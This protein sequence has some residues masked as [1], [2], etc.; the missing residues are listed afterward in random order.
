MK[1]ASF[2]RLLLDNQRAALVLLDESL[3]ISYLNATAEALLYTS[4]RKLASTPLSRFFSDTDT[5]HDVFSNCLAQGHPITCHE[6][7]VHSP[8]TE[9]QVNLTVSRLLPDR[10][11]PALLVEIQ[12]LDR[13]LRHSQEEQQQQ[14]HKAARHMVR[15]IA[16]EVKNPL[17][18]I[19]GA[20]QLLNG[21]HPDS[22]WQKCIDIIIDESDRL[23]DLT[24][25]LLGSKDR[26]NMH[27]INIHECLERARLLVEQE[28]PAVTIQRDYDPSL[29]NIRA[30]K[31]LLIQALLN[32]VRNAMQTLMENRIEN[33]FIT[34]R[35]RAQ[36]Q[37][38]IHNNHHRLALRIDIEDNGPGV[39]D[40][41]QNALF[42][43][44]VTGR[45]QGAGLGLSITQDIINHHQGM[46]ECESKPG[47]T[48]FRLLLPMNTQRSQRHA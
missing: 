21:Y 31:N 40:S 3:C 26:P 28:Q 33:G 9:T 4:W 29:P 42:F 22:Q 17:G 16:H 20:A 11:R 43:P 25:R 41:L 47:H 1:D 14:V 38:T 37:V 45:A 27:D 44:L 13:H 34:L 8:Y 23:S 7:E 18:G 10:S 48:C 32:L 5:I 24:N 2:Y 15:N 30:D 39:P 6:V 19:R 46:I 12:P 35:T 36:R